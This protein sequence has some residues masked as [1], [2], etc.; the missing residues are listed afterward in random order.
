MRGTETVVLHE[1]QV[2]EF[3][4]AV[5]IEHFFIDRA[6]AGTQ[7]IM[8]LG[9]GATGAGIGHFPEVVLAPH[10]EQVREVVAGLC[11]ASY[12][13]ASSSVGISPC[14]SLKTVV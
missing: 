10:V 14:S 11:Q 3:Y 12:W 6:F 4:E 5:A 8:D 13:G 7:V 2:P 9:A 1:D